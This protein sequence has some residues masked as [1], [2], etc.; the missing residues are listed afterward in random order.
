MVVSM[1]MPPAGACPGIAALRQIT[2][3]GEL[4]R[5]V[6]IGAIILGAAGFVVMIGVLLYVLVITVA[7]GQAW[8]DL[9]A[10]FG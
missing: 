2:R 8:L 1:L 10:E 7:L 5:G 4:G 9:G 3:T 6:A